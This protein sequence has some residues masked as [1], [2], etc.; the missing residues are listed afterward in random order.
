MLPALLLLLAGPSGPTPNTVALAKDASPP[1]ATIRDAAWLAGHWQ[2]RALGGTADEY[3]SEP[4]ARGMMG[5]FRLIKDDGVS[6]YEILQLV[7]HG[8]SLVLR[9][10]HFDRDLRGWEEKDVAREFRLARL[11]TNELFFEGMTFRLTGPGAITVF[12]AIKE[13]DG[14]I[15]EEK[16]DYRRKPDR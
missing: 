14:T 8:G 3:W 12:L 7:E 6:F 16:F 10:K 4:M 9:L 1:A 15:R 11:G 13:K 2:A 5:M